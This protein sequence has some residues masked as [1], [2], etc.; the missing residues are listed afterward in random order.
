MEPTRAKHAPRSSVAPYKALGP[1]IR[2]GGPRQS[3]TRNDVSTYTYTALEGGERRFVNKIMIEFC[4]V[5]GLNGKDLLPSGELRLVAFDALD[6][7]LY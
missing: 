1:P 2:N 3:M 7:A 5:G 4:A 6:D